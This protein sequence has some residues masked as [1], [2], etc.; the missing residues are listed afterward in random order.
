MVFIS[1]LGI[2]KA[3]AVAEEV[4][5]PSRNLPLGILSS[6]ALVTLLYVCTMVIVTGVFPIPEIA[7][8]TAPLADAGRVFLGV[9]GGVMVGIAGI[10]ATISTSNAAILSS[11]RYPFAM[12]RDALMT[13]WMRRIHPRFR[14]P[15]RAILVTGG[16][17]VGLALMLDVE[18]LARLGGVFGMLVFSLAAYRRRGGGT[19]PDTAAWSPLARLC[20]RLRPPGCG[21]VLL[22]A[23]YGRAKR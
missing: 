21:L 3:A 18:G 11:S 8:S 14:T 20:N 15:S 1:Y 12:G 17:M 19:G 2:V 5:N 10:L 22:A 6:V 13:L 16:V 23:A 4:E 7:A 9:V